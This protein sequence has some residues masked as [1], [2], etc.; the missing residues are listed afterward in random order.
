M[1]VSEEA[2][3][4]G[5]CVPGVGNESVC[6]RGAILEPFCGCFFGGRLFWCHLGAAFKS[7]VAVLGSFWGS[8]KLYSRQ[9]LRAVGEQLADGLGPRGTISGVPSGTI[10]AGGT[11]LGEFSTAQRQLQSEEIRQ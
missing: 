10:P 6:S 3:R 5:L 4:R 8:F 2:M 11:A 9:N 1:S 7:F